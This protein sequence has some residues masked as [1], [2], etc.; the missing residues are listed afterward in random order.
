MDYKDTIVKIFKF[1]INREKFNNEP[2]KVRAYE[3]VL[4]QIE[5]KE[6]IYSMKT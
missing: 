3:K 4:V 6:H 2:Y 1:L 5:D